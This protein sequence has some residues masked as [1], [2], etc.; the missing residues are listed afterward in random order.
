MIFHSPIPRFKSHSQ[1]I[2]L[3]MEG[4]KIELGNGGMK[5][6][7]RYQNTAGPLKLRLEAG[8]QSP[9]TS[10]QIWVLGEVTVP[11]FR[12]KFSEI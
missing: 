8:Q 6:H 12:L 9:V 5:N 10:G 7:S 3:G 2:Q 4:T 11:A 1:S